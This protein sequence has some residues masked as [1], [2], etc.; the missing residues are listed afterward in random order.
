[1]GSLLKGQR[2]FYSCS[3]S[4]EFVF[5]GIISC[6]HVLSVLSCNVLLTILMV[7]M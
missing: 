6:F 2:G 1:M 3:F 5:Y 7:D 4:S